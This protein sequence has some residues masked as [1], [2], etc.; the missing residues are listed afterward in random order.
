LKKEVVLE[1]RDLTKIYDLSKSFNVNIREEIASIFNNKEKSNSEFVALDKVSFQ[2]F[3]GDVL[4]IIGENGAGKST[5]LKIISE[6]T[7]PTQGE[8]EINGTVSSILEIG[9]G[10]HIELSGKENVYLSGSLKGLSR[11]KIDSY[12]QDIVDF[13][14]IEEF[15]N[16]PVKKY[17]NG[18]FVR[19]AFSVATFFETDIILLDEVLAVGDAE[20]KMKSLDRIKQLAKSGKTVILVSHDLSSIINLCTQCMILEQGKVIA[21]GHPKEMVAFYMENVLSKT[22]D[23]S[24]HHLNEAKKE[25]AQLRE[26]VNNREVQLRELEQH[27]ESFINE[28]QQLEGEMNLMKESLAEKEKDELAKEEQLKHAKFFDEE[29]TWGNQKDAPGNDY[30][31]IKKIALVRGEGREDIKIENDIRVEVEYWKLEDTPASI[32]FMLSYQLSMPF[33]I[34]NSLY[35]KTSE[36]GEYD[37]DSGLYSKSFTIP[38]NLLNNG[39]FSVDLFYIG[40]DVTELVHLRSLISFKIDY[41][42]GFW[43]KY[44]YDGNFPGPLMLRTNWTN[45]FSG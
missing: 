11:K 6:V 23:W 41:D 33:L 35:K 13:S 2:L 36:P 27:K 19:L 4:G 5:L 32:C 7:H 12:Y 24:G 22:S 45:Q 25:I 30:I 29:K 42:E 21:Q 1:A 18:M 26:D 37:T 15:M 9:S 20:F 44:N 17:S 31:R 34:G 40:K 28:K 39:V 38:G 16:T 10:F 14:G 43:K 8:V 3:N